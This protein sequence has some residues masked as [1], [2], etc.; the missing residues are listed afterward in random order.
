MAEIC[1]SAGLENVKIFN[2][3]NN[4]ERVVSAQKPLGD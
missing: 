1:D 3:L 4:I 2:D